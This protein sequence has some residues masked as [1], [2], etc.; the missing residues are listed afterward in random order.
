MTR[1]ILIL[2]AGKIGGAIVDLLHGSGA[3]DISLADS[4]ATFLKQAAGDRAK[5]HEIDVA[6]RTRADQDRAG[7]GCGALRP[8]LLPQPRRGAGLRRRRRALLR[9]DR[10][11]GDHA[12][13]QGDR[14][15]LEG[16]VRAAMRAG[17]RLHLDRRQPADQGV[18]RAARRAYAGRRA[19]GIPGQRAQIQSHLVDRRPHQRIL[20]PVRGDPR[21]Q[22][23]RGD[24]DGGP[25][26]FLA[27]WHRLRVL[28]HLRRPRHP[29][30]DPGRQARE[31]ELQD[32][33][34]SRPLR[35]HED[36]AGGPAA[37]GA[38]RPAQG[39]PRDLG[40]D[41]APGRGADLRR[42]HR[43]ARRAPDPGELCQEDL[44]PGDRR[45][46]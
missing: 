7:T 45:A 35:H 29:V 39:H 14:Q 20:Q 6:D 27:R 15:E 8:A 24:A 42:R 10:G 38:A 9:P 23:D 11:R 13:G 25:R 33:A 31:P 46:S 41:H 18:R 36:A 40:A 22:A 43:H 19:A 32:R 34:L 21:R 12:R 16:R 37:Q 3:Y 26:A 1:K 4:N 5:T 44:C 28:Q 30:R 2:G 17:A